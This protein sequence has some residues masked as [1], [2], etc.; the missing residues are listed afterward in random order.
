M[1][2]YTSL[3]LPICVTVVFSQTEVLW[4]KNVNT[5]VEVYSS[6]IQNATECRTQRNGVRVVL[7]LWQTHRWTAR[8]HLNSRR[9][10]VVPKMAVQKGALWVE[11]MSGF[12][13][14]SQRTFVDGT[15]DTMRLTDKPTNS[16]IR[17]KLCLKLEKV[18]PPRTHCSPVWIWL[19]TCSFKLGVYRV[20]MARWYMFPE[21]K[22]EN[23]LK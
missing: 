9:F 18:G 17:D 13:G 2:T 6:G 11:N 5:Q 14:S 16:A 20:L 1:L 12:D 8:K 23:C 10:H 22:W 19:V 15:V 21:K 7:C 4:K 3:P